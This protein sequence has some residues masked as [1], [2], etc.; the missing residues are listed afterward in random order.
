MTQVVSVKVNSIRPQYD[1]LKEWMND[2]NNVYIGRKGVVFIDGVRFPKYDSIWAN[3]FKIDNGCTRIQAINKY[4]TYITNKLNNDE[5]SIETLLT[6]KDKKLGCWCKD[7][8]YIPCH[9]DVL[10]ELINNY[11]V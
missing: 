3:P 2:P 7:N 4:R 9:G 5:I 11:K 6:L 10:V 8:D 1:N